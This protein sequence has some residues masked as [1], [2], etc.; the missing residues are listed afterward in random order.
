MTYQHARL[1]R[2]R[3]IELLS[4]ALLSFP[5]A[6]FTLTVLTD[7]AYW[8]TLNLLWLH[9]SEWL[10]FAGLVFGA[11]ALVVLA[12][13]FAISRVRPAWPAVL[14]GIGVMLLATLNSFVHTADG[15][16]AVM[17]YGLAL[18]ALTV[19]AMVAA[20]WLGARHG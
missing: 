11:L 7:I 5:V 9:F 4:S 1:D 17:P 3:P 16:T 2:H 19:V 14:A 20:A 15:W 12:I 6:C 18:S 10:L 13:D 8:Q